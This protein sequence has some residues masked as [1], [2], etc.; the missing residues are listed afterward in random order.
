MCLKPQDCELC[1]SENG[2]THSS[3]SMYPFKSC[4]HGEASLKTLYMSRTPHLLCLLAKLALVLF[5][6]HTVVQHDTC[7]FLLVILFIYI[8]NYIP[9][10]GY[11]S[12]NS[13]SHLPSLC[14]LFASI[15][16]L[17]YPLTHS[18]LTTLTSP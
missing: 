10:P 6:A 7:T 17:L 8:S 9:L 15:R 14:L 13:P 12:A 5:Q 16:I 3:V 4:V 1:L 2:V 18:H 11:P